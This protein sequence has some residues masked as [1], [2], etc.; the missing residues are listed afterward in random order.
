[1]SLFSLTK[2]VVQTNHVHHTF[3][4]DKATKTP[5]SGAQF[6]QNPQQKHTSTTLKKN[7]FFG[8]QPA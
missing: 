3:H 1:M 4:H 7:L 2:N 8:K 5:C 6:L